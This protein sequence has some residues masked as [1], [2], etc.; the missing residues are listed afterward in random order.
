MKKCITCKIPKILN[1]FHKWKFG[2]DG[3]KNQCKSCVLIR[4]N[5]YRE[6]NRNTLNKKQKKYYE[7]HKE[8]KKE[9]DL[10][11]RNENKEKISEYQKK[12]G[13]KN[14]KK[15]NTYA[16]NYGKKYSYIKA[17]RGLLYRSLKRMGKEKNGNTINILGYS[18][19]EFKNH[20]ES[21]FT[22]KMTWN[23]YGEWH[24]DHIKPLSSFNKETHP[25]IVNA[26][27][28]IQ[29]LWATTRE[30]NNIIYEGNINKGTK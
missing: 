19:L 22:E 14:R 30:I 15:L 28:N 29:P 13:K 23:N 3:Y 16:Y 4:Q 26:L 5:K 6:K 2:A 20:I 24:I 9:Y 10:I 25:S 18:S 12:Y 27:S 17:W 8:E 21:Q 11:Y 7:S 1:D